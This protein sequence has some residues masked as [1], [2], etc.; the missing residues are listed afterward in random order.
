MGMLHYVFSDFQN[1]VNNSMYFSN[2]MPPIR[3]KKLRVMTYQI[4]SECFQCSSRSTYNG[5]IPALLDPHWNACACIPCNLH[6]K[7]RTVQL[8][9]DKLIASRP[10]H[11]HMERG[12]SSVLMTSVALTCHPQTLRISLNRLSIVWPVMESGDFLR[13]SVVS[14]HSL[15]F[16]GIL[17]KI[18][19]N[20]HAQKK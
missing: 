3:R 14:G 18:V 11:L 16:L 7:N 2:W 17:K 10:K 9:R 12:I 8:G 4:F 13:S 5:R 20:F 15:F 1:A 19:C 6:P